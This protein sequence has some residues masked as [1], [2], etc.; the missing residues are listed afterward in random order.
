[1]RRS[2]ARPAADARPRAPRLPPEQ[3]RELLLDAALR[4]IDERGYRA[5]N[6]EAVA[7]EAGVSKPVPYHLFGDLG[8]LLQALLAREERQAL[9][10]LA[11]IVPA[12]PAGAAD[13]D[14]LLV[15]GVRGFLQAVQAAPVRWRLILRPTDGTPRVVHEHV[16]RG[17]RAIAAQVEQLL[18]WGI[19]QRGGPAGVDVEL[20]ARLLIGFAEQAALL[21]LNE[22][23]VFGPERIARYV[24]GALAAWRPP[25]QAG[26]T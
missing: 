2:P 14:R 20:T 26:A 1:M 13:A 24:R 16:D 17:R 23:E 21:V 5:A 25:R 19:A 3:R 7:R 22:G 18:H 11:T 8:S 10:Q 12:L 6:M 9:A 4:I 15:D